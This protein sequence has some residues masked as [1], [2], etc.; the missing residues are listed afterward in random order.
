MRGIGLLGGIAI[1]FGLGA[2]HATGELGWF[3]GVHLALG[4]GA[5]L[6]ELA[7]GLRKL[8]LP[9]DPE[10]RRLIGRG[11]L[12]IAATL[13]LVIGFERLAARTT[14]QLDWTL[15]RRFELS[16]AVR[17]ALSELPETLEATL[18]GAPF[19][20][21]LRRTRLLLETLATAGPV[22]VTERALDSAPAAQERFEVSSSNSVVLRLGERFETIARPSEATLYEALYRLRPRA[23]GRVRVLR[24]EGQG[25]LR[26]ID[27]LGF[28]GLAAALETEGYAVEA[29][30]SASLTELPA[31][32]DVLLLIG[33]RRSL[34]PGT[35]TALGRYLS[36]GGGFVA[37]LEPGTD[38]G[39]EALLAEHGLHSPDALLVDPAS[40]PLDG[41]PDGLCPL[42]FNYERHPVARGLDSNRMTFFCGTRAF[43]LRVPPTGGELRR[44]VLSSR[45]AWLSHDV[46]LL[47][48]AEPPQRETTVRGEYWPIV[49]AGRYPRD[50]RETR[51]VAFGD[52]DFAA[53]RNLRSLYNL[54][55]ILNA[56]HWA[57]D[58]EAEITTRPKLQSA[59]QFPLPLAHTL[60]SLY[61]VGLLVP[62]LL[63][64]AGGIVWLRRR[65]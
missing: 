18:F 27:A 29:S 47:E 8:R 32:T 6:F 57:A 35:L 51:I 5:V 26:R 12:A 21:R 40:G 60:R 19:D 16:P 54:D 3:S 34:H 7:A 41:L 36:R 1:A 45:D 56:V 37:L 28:S 10:S 15:E 14:L 62:E 64:I 2:Y 13:A 39:V 42:V 46:S 9:G 25:D 33:A 31:D 20:P 22:H 43:E 4:G 58:R 49:V 50:G 59:G 61:G 52:S 38:S 63:L 44:V 24:G 55:L 17:K 30:A 11:L 23:R 53:N 65:S 48:G